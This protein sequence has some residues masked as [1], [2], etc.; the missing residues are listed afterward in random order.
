MEAE[1]AK[2]EH[3]PFFS[4]VAAANRWRMLN[5]THSKASVPMGV[6]YPHYPF[7]LVLPSMDV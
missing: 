6:I 4:Y 7:R 1:D 3:H 5:K 2:Q